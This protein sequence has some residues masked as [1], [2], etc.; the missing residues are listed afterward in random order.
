[1]T[2]LEALSRSSRRFL[3]IILLL[4]TA[5]LSSALIVQPISALWTLCCRTPGSAVHEETERPSNSPRGGLKFPRRGEAEGEKER[6]KKKQEKRRWRRRL[7]RPSVQRSRTE[8]SHS[9][10]TSLLDGGKNPRGVIT[11]NVQARARPASK[12]QKSG[13]TAKLKTCLKCA[14]IL[15]IRLQ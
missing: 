5:A 6:E 15:F 9:P 4:S 12:R 14:N 1:M 3:S 11:A 10:L 8:V 2:S 7:D 13:I